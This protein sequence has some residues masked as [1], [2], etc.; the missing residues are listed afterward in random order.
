MMRIMIAIVLVMTAVPAWATTYVFQD[1][2]VYWPTWGNGTSDDGR[3]VIGNPDISGVVV[4]T[5]PDNSINTISV[6][7]SRWPESYGGSGLFI[8]T[9]GDTNWEYYVGMRTPLRA[10]GHMLKD[11]VGLFRGENDDAYVM[12]SWS[13][14]LREDH[15]V[16]IVESFH[17]SNDTI[18]YDYDWIARTLVFSD[19][20]GIL[21]LGAGWMIGYTIGC[22]NDVFLSS[23]AP[24][25]VPEPMTAILLGLGLL[26]VSGGRRW[27]HR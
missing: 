12:S 21:H 7:I 25:P 10:V 9:D 15:P 26:F 8:D 11:E 23:V 17:G 27:I 4:K 18:G 1:N 13:T 19:F 5:N 20:P 2:A 14:T 16:G 24:V 22:A 6:S 3:D